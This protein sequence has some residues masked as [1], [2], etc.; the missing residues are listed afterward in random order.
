MFYTLPRSGR[1]LIPK[2]MLRSHLAPGPEFVQSVSYRQGFHQSFRLAQRYS[3]SKAEG[4]ILEPFLSAQ[5]STS[6]SL[7]REDHDFQER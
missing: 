6:K 5:G 3:A 7:D 2:K 1:T 4:G